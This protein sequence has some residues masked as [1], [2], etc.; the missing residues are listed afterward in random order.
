MHL[1][2]LKNETKMI[3]GDG[4][5]RVAMVYYETKT[6]GPFVIRSTGMKYIDTTQ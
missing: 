2:V 3:D 4:W 5:W 1:N 6:E